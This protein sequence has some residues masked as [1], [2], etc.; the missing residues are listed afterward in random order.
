MLLSPDTFG[1]A[2]EFLSSSAA[3]HISENQ[4]NVTF[5]IPKECP[6]K[7]RPCLSNPDLE[8]FDTGNPGKSDNGKNKGVV[9][10]DIEE[11]ATPFKK[12][13]ASRRLTPIID[14]Q[15]RRS[16]RVMK[17]NN[18]FKPPTCLTKKCICCTPSP[19]T[20]SPKVIKNLAVQ[21]CGLDEDQVS[22][23]ALMNKKKKT[24][25]VAKT[26]D[27]EMEGPIGRQA[28]PQGEGQTHKVINDH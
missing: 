13:R 3:T 16:V 2:T 22:E 10:K 18:G 17:N 1:W 24:N 19:P 8:L 12:R 15:V 14:T 7:I 20:L 26:P 9:I 6:V 11:N 21:F 28:K 27:K 5:V 23:E 4:G 25:P